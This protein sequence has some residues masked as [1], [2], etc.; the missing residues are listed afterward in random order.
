MTIAVL[1][2]EMQ[3]KNT[4]LSLNNAKIMADGA[5]TRIQK[6]NPLDKIMDHYSKKHAYL[7]KD[8]HFYWKDEKMV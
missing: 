7:L 3:Q 2:E 1:A 4:P 8:K 6:R 5:I